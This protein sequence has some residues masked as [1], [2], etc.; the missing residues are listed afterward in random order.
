M[1]P[2]CDSSNN[3]HPT[4]LQCRGAG[5]VH[6]TN[7]PSSTTSDGP[8]FLP[9]Y[10]LPPAARNGHSHARVALMPLRNST[11][12]LMRGNAPPGHPSPPRSPGG[13]RRC[14]RLMKSAAQACDT[15]RRAGFSRCLSRGR[16]HSS[17]SNSLIRYVL[18]RDARA[19]GRQMRW[20]TSRPATLPPRR[21]SFV[22]L[23]NGPHLA[24]YDEGQTRGLA[25]RSSMTPTFSSG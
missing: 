9:A 8:S 5:A 10:C 3:D 16:R 25:A 12:T 4:A 18:P 20:A 13:A 19:S 23:S 11:R 7:G 22:A 14:A 17:T 2:S 24:C 1:A 6:H 21:A 15:G